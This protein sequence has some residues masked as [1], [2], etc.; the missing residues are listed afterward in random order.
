MK[1]CESCKHLGVISLNSTQNFHQ[2]RYVIDG[3]G[4]FGCDDI[5]YN[6]ESTKEKLLSK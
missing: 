6:D 4:N 1:P 5:E 2:G 3:N